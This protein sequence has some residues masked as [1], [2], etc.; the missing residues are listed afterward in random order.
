MMMCLRTWSEQSWKAIAQERI[1]S[2][3]ESSS[4]Q[5]TILDLENKEEVASA[6]GVGAVVFHDLSNN[7]IKDINF[8]WDEVLNFDGN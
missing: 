6:V 2:Q 8:M 5:A 1:T 4:L 3:T 7:R